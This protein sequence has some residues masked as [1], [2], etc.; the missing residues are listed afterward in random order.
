MAAVDNNTWLDALFVPSTIESD[1]VPLPVQKTL[2]FHGA[3]ITD[4]PTNG[5]TL[6]TVAGGSALVHLAD[7]NRVETADVYACNL[8][9]Y[10]GTLTSTRTITFP[11]PG[12]FALSYSRCIFNNG[13]GQSIALSVGTGSNPSIGNN[14][15]STIIF[16][17]TGCRFAYVP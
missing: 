7:S 2:N 5:A 9:T 4:D 17:P 6:I 8:I 11:L 13:T 16:E 15:T 10:T 1:S 12:S 3:N 14:K